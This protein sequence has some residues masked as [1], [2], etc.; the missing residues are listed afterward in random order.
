M[1][2]LLI[3]GG[4]ST[5]HDVSKKSC[6]NVLKFCDK[7]KYD[8]HVIYITKD[9]LWKYIQNATPEML[10]SSELDGA[11]AILSPDVSHG[12]ILV[13]NQNIKIDCIFP[14][15][16]GKNGEDG[17]I[18]GLF[19]I[20]Q[21]PYV[22]CDVTSSAN[23]MDKSITK[24]VVDTVGVNQSPYFLITKDD[25]V[26][27][28]D[29]AKIE[30]KFNYPLFVKPCASGSSVGVSKANNLAEL[31]TAITDA[32]QFD[33]K[34]LVETNIVGREIEVAVL[35]NEN[36][37]ASIAGEIAPTQ[38]FYSF[39]AKYV[40]DSSAL[41]I[42]ARID[43]VVM[44]RVRD[45]AIKVYKS[46]GCSGLSRVDFF[47]TAENDIVFNEINTLPGFTNISMYPKLFE[48]GGIGNLELIDHLINYA[49]KRGE[50]LG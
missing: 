31:K 16:H 36:P 13:G 43:G 34:V 26:E 37:I 38:E 49:L 19:E 12:G 50:R 32:L 7:N 48:Y 22:G 45:S 21:I 39:D 15:L 20:C 17:T 10:V 25:Y 35:G 14:V 46:L 30:Q 27:N 18:Q 2:L 1:N 47:V 6:A 33:R 24:L 3:F 4:R 42:P 11:C 5:E 29:T 41:Y 23:S 9:G 40:D 28:R 44:E 8:V